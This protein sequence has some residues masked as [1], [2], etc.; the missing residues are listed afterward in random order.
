MFGASNKTKIERKS[1]SSYNRKQNLAKPVIFQTA[2]NR[3]KKAKPKKIMSPL[4]ALARMEDRIKNGISQ[5]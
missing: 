3:N 4:T 1:Y 5:E 2:A